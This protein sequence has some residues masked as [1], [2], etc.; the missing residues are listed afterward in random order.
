MAD[1]PT[2]LNTVFGWLRNLA[3]MPADQMRSVI[4]LCSEDELKTVIEKLYTETLT[5]KELTALENSFRQKLTSTVVPDDPWSPWTML[6]L[7][8]RM[9]LEQSE[10]TA[11]DLA[12][13]PGDLRR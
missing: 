8:A 5:Y 12:A 6:F 10:A 1:I 11:E 13:T 3:A 2:L 4:E 7:G 9:R